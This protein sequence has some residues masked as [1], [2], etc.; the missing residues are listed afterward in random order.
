[1]VVYVCVRTMLTST[2]INLLK[3]LTM[4]H[5]KFMQKRILMTTI[6]VLISAI[7]VG[8]F[9]IAAFG[10]DPFQCLVAGINTVIPIPF[11]ILYMLLN[12]FLLIFDFFA[13]KSYI[14]IATFINL[15]LFGYM[16]QFSYTILQLLFPVASFPLRIGFLIIG[17]VFMS[18]AS[19]LYYTSN[20][21]VST[22]DAVPLI[23]SN[24]WKLIKF[25]YYKIICDLCCIAI[26]VFCHAISQGN[27]SK[28][29][30]IAGIGTV[31][32]AFFMGPL[33]EFF[34]V[35]ISRPWLNKSQKLNMI[36]V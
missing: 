31:I 18:F 30:S 6:G 28:I 16:V 12:I 3:E 5:N 21:G 26:G 1:M 35:H 10:V 2:I 8:F 13:D 22:Y 17:V 19:S 9:K 23:I 32:T 36:N 27:F 29:S 15:F 34:N 4:E 14:G 24:K 20:L 7:S 33:I 11:G 25:Q